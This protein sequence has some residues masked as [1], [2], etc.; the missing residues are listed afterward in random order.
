MKIAFLSRK[1]PV[2]KKSFSGLLYHMYHELAKHHTVIWIKPQQMPMRLRLQN[3]I[4]AL[5]ASAVNKK[6]LFFMTKPYA[7]FAAASVALQINKHK[8][9]AIFSAVSPELV[10][11]QRFDVPV[12]YKTDAVFPQLVN[13]YE[14]YT[15]LTNKNQQDG[16]EI[17]QYAIDHCRRFITTSEWTRKFVINKYAYN[18]AQT[19][20]VNFGFN[21]DFDFTAGEMNTIIDERIGRLANPVLL[22][23]SRTWERKGGNDALLLLKSLIDQSVPAVLNVVGCEPA[24]SELY[25]ELKQSV[26]VYSFF[27]K[28]RKEDAEKLKSLFLE[29]HLL[30]LP[31]KADCVPNVLIEGARFGMPLLSVKTGGVEEIVKNTKNGYLFEPGLPVTRQSEL[32]IEL[33][34]DY[35]LYKEMALHSYTLSSGEFSWENWGK[36]VSS[37]IESDVQCNK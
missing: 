18:P 12:F 22:F 10:F 23:V 24:P 35:A 32:V 14:Q 17:E 37:L 33:L 15:G 29:S 7:K 9:D 30:V 34:R 31:T 20:K 8:P 19:S 27:D 5:L 25:N 4:S 2:D 13:Y 3:K 6:H 26:R 11:R 36:E 1:N 21:F 16:N 28:N